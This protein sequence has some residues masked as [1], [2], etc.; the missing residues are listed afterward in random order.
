MDATA[1]I[2]KGSSSLLIL[3]VVFAFVLCSLFLILY[4]AHVYTTIRDR[5]ES[6]F[7]RRM[8]ISYITNKLRASDVEGGVLLEDGGSSLILSAGQDDPSSLLIYIYFHNGSIM[9]YVMQDDDVFDPLDGEAI[10][11]ADSFSIQPV[12][13]GLRTHIGVGQEIISF[14]VSM[15]S[16]NYEN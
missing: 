11:A 14:T 10:M 6:D 15:R 2:K 5:V 16:D 4:G 12:P 9:E 7:D 1:V 8:S 13:G 3:F